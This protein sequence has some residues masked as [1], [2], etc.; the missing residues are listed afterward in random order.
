MASGVSGEFSNPGPDPA[1]LM[2]PSTSPSVLSRSKEA[3]D[4]LSLLAQKAGGCLISLFKKI[5]VNLMRIISVSASA[6]NPA[7]TPSPI[8]AEGELHTRRYRKSRA[9]K[10][11]SN[12]AQIWHGSLQK[13]AD[14]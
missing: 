2:R 13:C 1:G 14:K 7:G 4:T 9:L 10:R 5:I 6:E 8:K 12:L 11:V 3:V